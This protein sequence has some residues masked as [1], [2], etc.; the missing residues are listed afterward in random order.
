MI[1]FVAST[2]SCKQQQIPQQ[3]PEF[4]VVKAAVAL[5]ICLVHTGKDWKAADLRRKSWD[6]LHKLWYASQLMS[7]LR[8]PQG[9]AYP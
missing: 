9:F 3:K 8:L 2:T 4:E 1:D 5:D 7:N 6:D